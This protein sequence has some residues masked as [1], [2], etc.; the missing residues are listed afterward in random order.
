[1]VEMKFRVDT[2][3]IPTRAAASATSL[4]VASMIVAGCTAGDMVSDA[5]RQGSG[6]GVGFHGLSLRL[7]IDE[8]IGRAALV[9]VG[10]PTR[11]EV[12]AFREVVS[13]SELPANEREDPI[14]LNGSFNRYDVD[15]ERVIKSEGDAPGGQI[16]IRTYASTPGVSVEGSGRPDIEIGQ[17]YLFI[18]FRGE[19]VW[20]NSWLILGENGLAPFDGD[21]VV[22]PSGERY[23]LDRLAK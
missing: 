2:R 20:Q 17:R 15:I 11:V 8:L 5:G 13:P 9:A 23:S 6:T 21:T 14:Y 1:M 18:L 16:D 10:K 4:V 19:G 3:R 22:F 7:S 12:A